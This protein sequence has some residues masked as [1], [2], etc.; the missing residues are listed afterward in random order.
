VV[1]YASDNQ[2]QSAPTVT[3]AKSATRW[4]TWRHIVLGAALLA[5]FGYI[6]LFS[7]LLAG[8]G[9][10]T[11]LSLQISQIV[12]GVLGVTTALAVGGLLAGRIF[13]RIDRL[14]QRQDAQFAIL[15][16]QYAELKAAFEAR[17]EAGENTVPLAGVAQRVVGVYASAAVAA[18]R[19][20]PESP[21]GIVGAVVDELTE[22]IE[23]FG[24]RKFW[25]GV[26]GCAKVGLDGVGQDADVVP[27][28]S[29]RGV[30]AQPPA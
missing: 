28:Q 3:D 15:S 18:V 10:E 29:A 30:R 9:N 24:N 7:G 22:R 14:Q 23:D 20:S 8:S 1:P 16:A 27:L 12:V 2:L 6:V 17:R 11:V 5:D 21:D 4:W 19:H 13:D 26:A 25:R